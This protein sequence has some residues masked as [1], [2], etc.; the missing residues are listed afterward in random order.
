[1]YKGGTGILRKGKVG[2][3]R[4][5]KLLYRNLYILKKLH[6][7]LHKVK[8]IYQDAIKDNTGKLVKVQSGITRVRK[9]G[10]SR[11]LHTC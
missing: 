3:I 2:S 11:I 1:M 8:C 10:E 9:K 7:T 5:R 4:L 6:V